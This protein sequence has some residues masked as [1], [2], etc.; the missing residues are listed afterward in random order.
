MARITPTEAAERLASSSPAKASTTG[1]RKA[2]S[3]LPSP[4]FVRSVGGDDVFLFRKG[5]G[6]IVAPADDALPADIGSFD[7]GDALS[8]LPEHVEQWLSDYA[9]EVRWLQQG[10]ILVEDAPSDASTA[11]GGSAVAQERQ[12]TPVLCTAKWAQGHPYNARLK[13]PAYAQNCVVGCVAVAIGQIMRYWGQKGYHRGS[14]ATTAY[15][16]SGYPVEVD[17]LPPLTAFDYAHLTDRTPKTTEEIEAVAT[18]LERVGKAVKLCYKE[19]ATSGSMNVYAPLMKS[20]LRL[21]SAIRAI[22]AQTLGEEKFEQRIYEEIA[23]GRPVILRGTAPVGGHAFVCDGY[24]SAT[25]KFHINWGW[26]GSYDG[27]YRMSALDAKA[28]YTFNSDKAAVI[29]IQ[30]DYVLG[31]ANGD[32]SVTIADAMAIQ[33]AVFQGGSEQTDV[34]SDGRTDVADLMATVSHVLKGDT[35]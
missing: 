7:E 23:A 15:R 16:Y 6:G 9:A 20:R 10:E 35:L 27:Y 25:G 3:A 17:A 5:E 33:K 29:G 18:L 11:S 21:G 30:P 12:D 1:R 8:P 34:N 22:Y 19:K 26:G 13:F 2:K 28:S 32:G 24:S 4:E 14:T 31:D